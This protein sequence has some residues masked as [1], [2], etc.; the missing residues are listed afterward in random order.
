MKNF[1]ILILIVI[2][3]CT[4]CTDK[5][6]VTSF[7]GVVKTL[8]PTD[9]TATSAILRGLVWITQGSADNIQKVGF[10]YSINKDLTDTGKRL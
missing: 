4:S 7:E 6:E 9:V 8:K 2:L 5:E 1:S 3:C 10:Y